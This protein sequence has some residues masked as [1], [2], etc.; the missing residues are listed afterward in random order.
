ML[1]SSIEEARQ[2]NMIIRNASFEQEYLEGFDLSEIEFDSTELTG[3]TFVDCSFARAS[4]YTT[5]FLNCDFSNCTFDES[6]WDKSVIK[7]CKGNGSSFVESNFKN[8]KIIESFFKYATFSKSVGEGCRIE[9]S[10]FS[11]ALLSDMT[12]KKNI[13]DKV[14]LTSA[15]FFRTSL[16]GVDLSRCEIAGILVSENLTELKGL[17][18]DPSQAMELVRFLEVKVV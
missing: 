11:E 10:N 4:F 9:G 16:K 2:G 6:Y 12:L 17:E 18:I 1:E 3:C 8:S 13:L 14:D 7:E 15:D 5:T